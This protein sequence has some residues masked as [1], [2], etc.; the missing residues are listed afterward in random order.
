MFSNILVVCV[1]NICRSPTAEFL[2]RK[3]IQEKGSKINIASA[4]V[5]A[6][7]GKPAASKAAEYAATIGLDLSG[8]IARQLTREMAREYDL[9]LVMEEGHIR[10]VEGIAPEARGKVHLLGRW[11]SNIEIPDPYRKGDQAFKHALDLI[12]VT[13]EEW[14]GKLVR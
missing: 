4:G 11:H 9:I 6:L 7:V 12:R 10:A 1:G 5:G 14:V 3:K 13:V 2:L 8:H